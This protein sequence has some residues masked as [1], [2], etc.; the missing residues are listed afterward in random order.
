MAYP[1]ALSLYEENKPP[2]R[3][4]GWDESLSPCFTTT[5]QMS[6]VAE[7]LGGLKTERVPCSAQD[8]QRL[9]VKHRLNIGKPAGPADAEFVGTCQLEIARCSQRK[10]LIIF[11]DDFQANV[12]V[13]RDA[14]LRDTTRS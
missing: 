14:F 9:A 3:R 1:L 13:E 6:V 7:C 2:R 11:G 12:V 10:F 8:R 4:T 5:C